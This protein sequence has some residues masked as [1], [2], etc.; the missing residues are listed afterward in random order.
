MSRIVQLRT[1]AR[2]KRAY[3]YLVSVVAA[4]SGLL[5]GFDTAVINGALPFLRDEFRLSDAE[6]EIAASGLL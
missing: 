3:V 5:F 2:G 6:L 4:I 1:G